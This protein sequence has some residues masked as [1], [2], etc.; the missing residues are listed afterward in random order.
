MAITRKLVIVLILVNFFSFCNTVSNKDLYEN[1]KNNI[2]RIIIEFD[3]SKKLTNEENKVII[4]KNSDFKF[5]I[6][7]LED[8]KEKYKECDDLVQKKIYNYIINNSKYE[9][10]KT[11]EREYVNYAIV[12]YEIPKINKKDYEVKINGK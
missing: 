3:N 6:I 8:I 10:I 1:N 4:K 12:E 9:I 7:I 2:V 5:Q 11:F